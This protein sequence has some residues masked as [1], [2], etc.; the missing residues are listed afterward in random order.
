MKIQTN[1]SKYHFIPNYPRINN[2]FGAAD[3]INLNYIA[4]NRMHVLPKRMQ[5]AVTNELKKGN[6]ENISLRDLHLKTYS[7]ILDCNSLEELKNEYREFGEVFQAN[8]VVKHK[9]PNIK[10]IM[11]VIP[12]EDLSLFLAKERW[13]K[14][15]TTDE[16]AKTLGLKDR[17]AINWF[18]DKIQLPRFEKNYMVLLRSTDENLNKEIADK[19]RAYNL[20]HR[21]I[22][23]AHNRKVSAQTK[24]IQREISLRAW[25]RV[26]HIREALSDMAKTC[27]K[28]VLMANFWTK[29]PDYAKEYGEAKKIVAEEFKKERKK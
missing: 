20:N 29:Y 8:A 9:S 24:E 4:K 28:R 3:D 22:V 10:K 7:K 23:L 27:D 21:D 26:P 2:N 18:L 5:D 15:K 25:D 19:M 13:A 12:L 16:L 1:Y 17:G 6:P 11:K 14:L